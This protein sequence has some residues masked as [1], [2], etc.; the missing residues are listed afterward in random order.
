LAAPARAAP[1]INPPGDV[2]GHPALDLVYRQ[3]EVMRQQIRLLA[4][5]P[6]GELDADGDAATALPTLSNLRTLEGHN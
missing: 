5:E 2:A 3:L 1:A 6:G 4:G